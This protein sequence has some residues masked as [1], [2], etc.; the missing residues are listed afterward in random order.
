VTSVELPLPATVS[1]PT[2]AVRVVRDHLAVRF[3]LFLSAWG[4]LA[5]FWFNWTAFIFQAL[6][7]G[8][9]LWHALRRERLLH[10]VDVKRVQ[11]EL[12]MAVAAVTADAADVEELLERATAEICRQSHWEFGQ[13]WLPGENDSLSLARTWHGN[14]DDRFSRL[15]QASLDTSF[16]PG[17]GLPGRVLETRVAA[18]ATSDELTRGSDLGVGIGFAFPVVVDDNVAAILEF[19]STEGHVQDDAVADTYTYLSGQLGQVVKRTHA[20]AHMRDTEERLR[21]LIETLPLATYIDRPGKATGTIWVSPQMKDITSYEA[22]EWIADPWLFRKVLHPEDH[23]RVVAEMARVKETGEPLDHEYRMIR[24]DGSIVWLHDSA[25]TITI[26]GTAYTRGF[27]VDISARR[28]AE[29]ERDE[30]LEQLQ[31]Q[32][33]ELRQVDHLKDEFVAL[34]SHE[35]R[36]PLTSI[37]GYLE[38]MAEDTNLTDEQTHFMDTIDRNAVRLQRVVGDLLFLAQVEAGKLTLEQEDVDVNTLV[39]DALVAAR[40][41]AETKSVELRAE[42][43]A[44]PR[45]TGDRAR[46]AQVLDNF[47][48]N[49]IKFTPGGGRVVVSTS[50]DDGAVQV[51]ISDT[52]VGVPANELP[53]LFERFFRTSSATSQA[54]QGTGLGLAIAKAIVEGH[55]GH[56][57]V[58]SEEGVGTTFRFALPAA[59]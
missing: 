24:R 26:D 35:L 38:L 33:E 15:R 7:A 51:R 48:S 49:A 14:E 52:G 32:N 45:I 18:W 22:D 23:D 1:L 57:T 6:L 59:A 37:R 13:V 2:R 39:A 58:E 21:S 19:F 47:V 36:T 46:L 25:V 34:V 44:V 28:A 10:K 50:A 30:I 42:T 43:A 4:A 11:L 8:A 16:R 29:S 20:E 5:L 9:V 3:G 56:V 12:V 27:I 17:E 40:P 54:V 41:A 53:R 31:T 55:A